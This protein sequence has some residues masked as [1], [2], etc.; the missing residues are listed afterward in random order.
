MAYNVRLSGAGLPTMNSPSLWSQTIDVPVTGVAIFPADHV[1]S[2]APTSSDWEHADITYLDGYGR[3]VDDASYG[4][5]AWTGSALGTGWNVSAQQYGQQLGDVSNT[6]ESPSNVVWSLSANAYELAMASGSSASATTAQQEASLEFYNPSSLESV[7]VGAE[8][9]DAY[10]PLHDITTASGVAREHTNDAY[11]LDTPGTYGTYTNGAAFS[12][13]PLNNLPWQL[14]TQEATG[15]STTADP[16]TLSPSAMASDFASTSLPD[17][18][19]TT[20]YYGNPGTQY[21]NPL[22]F[23]TPSQ[24]VTNTGTGEA[25][26]STTYLMPSGQTAV[27]V[28]PSGLLTNQGSMY[29]WYWDSTLS[30]TPA[31]CQGVPEF[32]GL[33]CETA[34]GATGPGVGSPVP[35]TR[36][37][38]NVNLEPNTVVKTVSGTQERAMVDAYDLSGRLTDTYTVDASGTSSTSVDDVEPTYSTTT[39]LQ[40]GAQYVTGDVI[41]WG[42]LTTAGTPV[43]VTSSTYDADGRMSSS[44]D[45]NAKTTT[46]LY[47]VDSEV[48]QKLEPVT[49]TSSG[50]STCY[51]YGGTDATG[52]IEMRPL[53]TT[54]SVVAGTSCSG[55]GAVTYSAAYDA[56]ANATTLKYP[57][58]MVATTI[59]NPDDQATQL[60]YTQGGTGVLS[61]YASTVM[62]FAQSYNPFGQV[63]TASSP[64]SSQVYAYDGVG[65]LTGVGDNFEGSCT[66]RTYGLDYDSNRTSFTSAATTPVGGAC[67]TTS[68]ASPTATSVFDTIGSGQ[69]GSDRIISSTWNTTSGT[70]T[71]NYAYDVLGR[72]TTIPGVDTQAGGTTGS[73]NNVTLA[74]RSDD[75]VNSLVQG[76]ACESFTYDPLGD[77]VTTSNYASSSCSGAVTT[78]TNDYAG[79]SS[80]AWTTTG[81]STTAFFDGITQGNALNVTLAGT[82]SPSCLGISTASCTLNLTDMRGDIVATA[83]LTSGTAT[84]S[85]YSETTEFGLPR[86]ASTEAS[87]AP[88]YGWLGVH[89]KAANNL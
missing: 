76:S 38:Y 74:Y 6:F 88:T 11:G 79:G 20:N 40:T 77:V 16:T 55:A 14:V 45:A 19:V 86:S 35:T 42:T 81:S 54:E 10:G 70:V 63:A 28:Q 37:T 29:D 21:G 58:A 87:V 84:V 47:N 68:S 46:Y 57:N 7:P 52:N 61:G 53:L 32:Y 49:S 4:D 24:V 72:Q 89:E 62:T 44:T 71:G 67:P 31:E 56:D 73:P 48:V 78:S 36:Y 66:T 39:G 2:G 18:R 15:Y 17:Y 59:F 64:E 82:A 50:L 3:A 25:I 65:R 69:G 23:G 43:S 8:L 85:G 51:S 27:S 83:A 5:G 1:P 75:L 41:T 34:P 60:A 26:T 13:N 9:T 80:P 12:F 30:G 22:T 33:L